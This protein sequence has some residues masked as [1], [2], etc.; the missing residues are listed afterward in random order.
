MLKAKHLGY[1]TFN[2]GWGTSF[3]ILNRRLTAPK[4]VY[5]HFQEAS[6][7]ER[8]FWDAQIS[9]TTVVRAVRVPIDSKVSQGD[10]FEIDG[11]QYEVAQKD[12]KTDRR[13]ESWLLSL[14]SASIEYRKAE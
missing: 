1:Q 5:I 3:G 12:R 14:R 13:P 10:V 8:R 11:V 6:V 9:G 2:D 4:Q 7:G